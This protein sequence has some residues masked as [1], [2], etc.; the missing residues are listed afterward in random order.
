MWIRNVLMIAATLASGIPM[1]AADS[2]TSKQMDDI[3]AELR[4]IRT[5]LES[6]GPPRRVADGQPTRVTLDIKDAPVLGS[7]DAQVTI[8][9]FMDYQC[10]YCKRFHS[11][12]FPD[13]K[14]LYI[15]TGKI[16]F[17]VMDFP[18]DV[19]P[20]ALLAAQAGRCAA[21]QGKF[22]AIH[23]LMQSEGET[24][25]NDKIGEFAKTSALDVN[26]LREC[27]ESGKY[28]DAIRLGISEASS[29][30][31]QAT[32]TFVV[33][34]STQT[35]VEGELVLGAMPF[36]IFQKKIDAIVTG[37]SSP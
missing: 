3:L 12:T 22:W 11:Q 26:G 17:Y 28:K 13:L 34:K 10:P 27:L 20:K 1:G 14:K 36:G 8:V 25:D 18:L 35:G 7:K 31:I 37:K 6:N 32:P 21:E 30:G 24:L 23:D 15:D 5:L 19:H 4:Q 33:G 2:V 16:R 9:E 29:K